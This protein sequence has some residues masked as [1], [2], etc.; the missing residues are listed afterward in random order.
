MPDSP[1]DATRAARSSKKTSA[2]TRLLQAVAFAA[3][4]VPLGSVA[5]EADTIRCVTSMSG[6]GCSG[7]G[8]YIGGGGWQSN[9]WEYYQNGSYNWDELIYTFEI[10]GEPTTTFALDVR[11]EVTTQSALLKGG[12]L[13]A[14]RTLR[15]CRH[16]TRAVVVCST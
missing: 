15:A 9:T 1:H 8:G 11:D 5:I 2:A 6:G 3:V 13:P 10:A 7:T 12:F 4:L 14:S 16:S